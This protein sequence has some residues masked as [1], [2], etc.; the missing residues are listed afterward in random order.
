MAEAVADAQELVE[1]LGEDDAGDA[2]RDALERVLSRRLDDAESF[3]D[4]RDRLSY[5]F[6]GFALFALGAL[7][8]TEGAAGMTRAEALA[9]LGTSVEKCLEIA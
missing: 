7:A 6:Y 8:M 9:T 5:L 2:Y 3:E 1:A 4:F